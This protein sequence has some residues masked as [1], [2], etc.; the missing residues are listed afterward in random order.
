VKEKKNSSTLN[1]KSNNR[2]KDIVPLRHGIHFVK[3]VNSFDEIMNR[4]KQIDNNTNLTT[5][6][7]HLK[8]KNRK[9]KK[10]KAKTK[11]LNKEAKENLPLSKNTL[12]TKENNQGDSHD[13]E[14]SCDEENNENDEDEDNDDNED[15]ELKYNHNPKSIHEIESKKIDEIFVGRQIMNNQNN[16]LSFFGGNMLN[17]EIYKVENDGFKNESDNKLS[18]YDKFNRDYMSNFIV[19]KYSIHLKLVNNLNKYNQLFALKEKSNNYQ[20]KKIITSMMDKGIRDNDE[21]FVNTA[22]NKDS[23]CGSNYEYVKP[24]DSTHKVFYKTT[25]LQPN[26]KP[27]LSKRIQSA[28]NK[29]VTDQDRL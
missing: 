10:S 25:L 7:K 18:I 28:S 11:N 3:K 17:K 12:D 19:N 29:L 6:K 9:S 5:T 22:A 23:L 24:G 4:K 8:K 20:S 1:E 27:L 15:Y 2:D 16:S 13:E 26:S 14:E 21:K